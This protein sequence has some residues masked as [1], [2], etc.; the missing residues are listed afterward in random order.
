MSTQ[1]PNDERLSQRRRARRDL[2]E[3][4]SD[5]IYEPEDDTRERDGNVPRE[6]GD[7]LTRGGW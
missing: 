7:A 3:N 4:A 1:R 5:G 2:L 6:F